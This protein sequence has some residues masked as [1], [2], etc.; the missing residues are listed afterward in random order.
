MS[1]RWTNWHTVS[2][3]VAVALLGAVGAGMPHWTRLQAWVATMALLAAMAVIA[4]QGVTGAWWGVLVDERNKL[5]LSRL[6]MLLWTTI[7]LAGLYVAMVSNVAAGQPHPLSVTIPTSVLGM[8]GIGTT[9]M[10]SSPLIRSTKRDQPPNP[11]EASRA[12]SQLARRAGV[13]QAEGH[14]ATQG[15]IVVNLDPR[16]ARWA[17][18]FTG[19]EVGDATTISLGKVQLFY[20][21]ILLS[22]AY[23]AGIHHLLA[24][25]GPIHAFPNVDDGLVALL[26]I[27]NAGYL[28]EK[29]IPH[30]QRS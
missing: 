4:G 5:G 23:A 19:E 26:G 12:L 20:F 29:A 7:V 10:F 15:K 30:S 25:P 6:Q 14:L 18:L 17:D 1:T 24:G 9:A 22:L 8:L 16:M 28:V 27:S 3:A 13:G 11:E 21:T 2:L